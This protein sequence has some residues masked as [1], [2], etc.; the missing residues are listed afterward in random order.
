[1]PGVNGKLNSEPPNISGIGGWFAYPG[2]IG[3]GGNEPG[4]IIG[5]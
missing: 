4:G 1:M 5:E 3:L 2:G